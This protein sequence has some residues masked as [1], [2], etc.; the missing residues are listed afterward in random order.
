MRF[1]TFEISII[2][3]DDSVDFWR[4]RLNEYIDQEQ[5][6]FGYYYVSNEKINQFCKKV[7][8]FQDINCFLDFPIRIIN[9]IDVKVPKKQASK[10]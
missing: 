9:S 10:K 3:E 1:Y 6:T 2:G 7:A 4:K 8:E 5:D